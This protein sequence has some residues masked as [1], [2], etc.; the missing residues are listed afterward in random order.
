MAEGRR[1]APSLRSLSFFLFA[2]TRRRGWRK[3]LCM[4]KRHAMPARVLLGLFFSFL[5]LAGPLPEARAQK[6]R[7]KIVTQSPLSGEQ[8]GTGEPL[9][10][11]AQLAV[12]EAGK[13]VKAVRFDLVMVPHDDQ[14][15]PEGGVPN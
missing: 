8:A 4:E 12:E 3:N 2:L 7:I 10:L 6:G 1:D 14:A 13:R 11:R 9:Q 15:K 5:F